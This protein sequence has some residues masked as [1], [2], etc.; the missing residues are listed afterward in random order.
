MNS[1]RKREYLT[2]DEVQKLITAA[3]SNR[4]GHRDATMLLVEF[5]CDSVNCWP[6]G[7]LGPGTRLQ[8]GPRLEY[9]CIR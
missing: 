2:S 9:A 4:W 6:E 3:K 8:A 5:Q 7:D 1:N